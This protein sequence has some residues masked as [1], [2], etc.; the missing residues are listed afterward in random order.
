MNTQLLNTIANAL[1]TTDKTLVIN[2]AI[3]MLVK[4]GVSIDKAMDAVC[5]AGTYNKLA[6]QVW[7]AAQA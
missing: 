7:E 4:S 3:A 1:N 5:G 2:T 6:A